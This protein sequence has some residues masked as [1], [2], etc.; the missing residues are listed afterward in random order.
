ME[1]LTDGGQV[2]GTGAPIPPSDYAPLGIV[3]VTQSYTSLLNAFTGSAGLVSL[4]GWESGR[5]RSV[6][7]LYRGPLLT[8]HRGHEGRL[9]GRLCRHA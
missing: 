9:V 7:Y 3:T 5:K 1:E 4:K 6:P 8:S 2:V